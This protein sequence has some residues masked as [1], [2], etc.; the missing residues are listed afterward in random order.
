MPRQADDAHIVA[1]IFAAELRADAERLGELVDL[2]FERKI[3][4]GMRLLRALYGERVEVAGGGELHRLH[5]LLG[6]EAAD[7][8][9]EMV[10]RA[11]GGAE[12]EDLLLEKGE[13]PVMRQD[14]GRRLEEEAFVGAPA[15]L[16]DEQELIGVLALGVDLDL[17][18]QVRARVLLLEHGEGRELRITQIALEIGVPHA[19]GD[20]ALVLALGED[21]PALLSHDDRGAGILAHRQHAARR[22]IGVLEKIIS[23]EF[24]VRGRLGVIEDARELGEMTRAQKMVD[25]DESLLGKQPYGL[26]LD[27]EDLLAVEGLDARALL[28]ELAV[29]RRVPD[30]RKKLLELISHRKGSCFTPRGSHPSCIGRGQTETGLAFCFR[31][32]PAAG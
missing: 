30:E 11:G 4:E 29:R 10:G 16:G 9:G 8:D 20:R 28:R 19:L 31:Q 27:R 13:E 22:D 25:V 7:D 18:R 6:R 5:R 3:A 1:E 23:D 32:P 21:E 2:G 24:V 26:A 12:R 17:R 14:R 15:A